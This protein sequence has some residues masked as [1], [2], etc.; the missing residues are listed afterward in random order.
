[1]L[2]LFS[3]DIKVIIRRVVGWL[4]L[5]Q[6]LQ[7]WCV[8]ETVWLS[9]FTVDYNFFFPSCNVTVQINIK[10]TF[11]PVVLYS[12]TLLRLFFFPGKL[13]QIK[14]DKEEFLTLL[15]DPLLLPSDCEVPSQSGWH[16]QTHCN[17]TQRS[18]HWHG[19]QNRDSSWASQLPFV[20]HLKHTHK[21]T[22]IESHV[23]I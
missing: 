9:F 15:L 3:G 18:G 17:H 7:Q 8:K 20:A 2:R 22:I 21:H 14:H 12:T 6:A 5:R 10:N 4:C 23:Q 19:P 1:M 13:F 11:E 16:K